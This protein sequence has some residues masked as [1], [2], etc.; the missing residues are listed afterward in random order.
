VDDTQLLAKRFQE[1]LLNFL[2]E[3]HTEES[4]LLWLNAKRASGNFGAVYR[5][6]HRLAIGSPAD[7][8]LTVHSLASF[9]L[10]VEQ[11]EDLSELKET[12][13]KLLARIAVTL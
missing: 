3:G 11:R 2:K 1:L 4:L 10:Y 9:L 13:Y 6:V 12:G 8:A 5:R 7:N